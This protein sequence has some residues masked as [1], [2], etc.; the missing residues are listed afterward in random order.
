MYVE[1]FQAPVVASTPNADVVA[2]VA[3]FGLHIQD[4]QLMVGALALPV[5][6]VVA[7]KKNKVEYYKPSHIAGAVVVLGDGRVVRTAGFKSD[8][9]PMSTLTEEQILTQLGEVAPKPVE[10]RVS[11]PK[12]EATPAEKRVAK[13][14]RAQEFK[15]RVFDTLY[16]AVTTANE[17]IANGECG[18]NVQFVN[19]PE[20]IAIVYNTY[21]QASEE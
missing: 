4:N 19:H 10:K 13:P 17:M 6:A 3:K 20:G 1:Y 14:K 8:G 16:E 2:K 9:T 15:F 12:T 18:R 21:V 7:N 11:K 5:H